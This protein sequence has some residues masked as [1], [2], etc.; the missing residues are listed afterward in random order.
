[1]SIWKAPLEYG[2]FSAKRENDNPHP[3]NYHNWPG[4]YFISI[5]LEQLSS[6]KAMHFQKAASSAYFGTVVGYAGNIFM[7][8]IAG[9]Q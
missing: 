4:V 5:L 1:M 8:S 7:K 6:E 2:K 3:H 9:K